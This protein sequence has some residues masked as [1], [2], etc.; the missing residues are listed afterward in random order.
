V[1]LL[2]TGFTRPPRF[3]P[4]AFVQEALA[5]V[6]GAWHVEAVLATTLEDAR[7]VVPPHEATLEASDD[8]V[9]IRLNVE[10]LDSAARYLVRLGWP[11]SVRQPEELRGVLQELSAQ[12]CRASEAGA[13]A[14]EPLSSAP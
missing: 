8:G 4:L 14:V 6:P 7:A 12:I 10:D 1:E 13:I 11:F 3:D 5:V 9:L 2:E